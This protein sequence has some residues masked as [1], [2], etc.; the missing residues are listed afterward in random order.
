VHRPSW[1]RDDKVLVSFASTVG[2]NK[3]GEE[4]YVVDPETG[5]R[6]DQINDELE[7]DVTA[8]L[9]GGKTATVR[10]VSA[11]TVRKS[12]ICV[13]IYYDR[14]SL[15]RYK[16]VLRGRLNR[17][18]SKSLGDLIEHGELVVHHGHGSPSADMRTGEIPYIKVSDL[19]AGQVNINPTNRVSQVVAERH[20]RGKISGLKAFDLLTPART[21]KNI[22]D[23]A[24]LMPGQERVVLTKEMLV[25]RPGPEAKFDSFYLLW[26][27]SLSIVREQW[28]RLVFMQTNREDTGQRFREIEIPMAP[29]A[30]AAGEV[31][32]P[33]RQYYEGMASLR[34]E[35]LDYLSQSGCHHVFLASEAEG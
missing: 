31:A 3:D 16:R 25:I 23:I 4:L 1:F 27:L 12:G 14:R 7:R 17:F 19:R 15:N 11:G 5:R 10:W 2:I 28:E 24:V 20:W 30:K 13:P 33:F 26:A 18:V 35:F 21:S 32:A 29:N 8:V 22:G 34:A 9:A 6:T